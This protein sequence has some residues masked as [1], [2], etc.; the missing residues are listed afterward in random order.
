LKARTTL[1]QAQ[2]VMKNQIHALLTAE[3]MED[4]KGSLQSKKGRKRTLDTLSQWE[5]GLSAQPLVDTI[6]RL[7]ENVK[8]IEERLRA[9]AA[10]DRTVELLKTIPGC[11]EIGAWTIRAYTDDIK[12]F[13]SAKKYAAYAGLVPWVQSS[14]EKVRYGKITK[15]GPK[16]LRTALVQVVMGMRRM[17][18]KTCSWRLMQR[19]EAMKKTKSHPGIAVIA[20]ARKVATVIWHMLNGD[21]EFDIGRMVDRKPAKK[22]GPAELAKEALTGGREKP[23]TVRAGKKGVKKTGVAGGKKRKVG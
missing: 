7:E 10:G 21:S 20:A 8:G 12:R 5:N 17:K 14:N 6:E 13:T 22:S 2:V 23:V 16:E 4:V 9:L 18:A 19:Y 11:G 1:V 15:R 3:G